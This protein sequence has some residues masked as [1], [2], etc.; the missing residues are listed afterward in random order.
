[1]QMAPLKDRVLIKP[2]EEEQVRQQRRAWVLTMHTQ[3][4]WSRAVCPIVHALHGSCHGVEAWS[5]I[6]K[7]GES[8]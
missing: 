4:V 6:G 2:L 5:C 3:V 1:M 7:H 8:P